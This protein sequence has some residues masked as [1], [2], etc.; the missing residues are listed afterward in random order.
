MPREVFRDLKKTWVCGRRINISRVDKS[1]KKFT[2]PAG[3]KGKKKKS[4]KSKVPKQTKR[5]TTSHDQGLKDSV[6]KE[7]A[8]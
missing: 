5:R 1:E 3:E 4:K 7:S 2:K 8:E 6:N